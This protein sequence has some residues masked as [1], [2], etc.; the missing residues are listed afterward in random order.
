MVNT[1]AKVDTTQYRQVANMKYGLDTGQVNIDINGL[2]PFI[3]NLD[4]MD[5]DPKEVDVEELIITRR[6]VEMKF[7]NPIICNIN[8]HQFGSSMDCGVKFTGKNPEA[9]IEKI[10]IAQRPREWEKKVEEFKEDCLRRWGRKKGEIK[11]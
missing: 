9:L 5:V 7:S 2:K 11:I 1:L 4:S 10:A 8:S 3:V 6:T